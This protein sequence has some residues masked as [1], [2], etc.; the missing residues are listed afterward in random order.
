MQKV[1]ACDLIEQFAGEMLRGG[2]ARTGE[3]NL[4]G[5]GFG[6]LD[7]LF[8]IIGRKI[9]T[10]H[11]QEARARDLR[12]RRQRRG[13]VRH[14]LARDRGDDLARRHDA[15]RVTVGHGFRDQFVAENAAGA[16]LVLDNDRLAE[17]VLHRVGK[18]APDNVG[19]AAGAERDDDAD[20][21]LR[22]LLR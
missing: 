20:R 7:E 5:I 14:L 19:A 16:R 2:K 9:R 11:D 13:V 17:P 6:L 22:P 10:R 1:D 8:D 18:N 3:D 4:A 15:E 21:L 12:H